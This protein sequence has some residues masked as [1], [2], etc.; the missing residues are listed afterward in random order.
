MGWL[1][2]VRHGQLERK[3]KRRQMGDTWAPTTLPKD[4]CVLL[5]VFACRGVC[6]GEGVKGV[7]REGGHALMCVRALINA[8]LAR[9]PCHSRPTPR[10]QS[11]SGSG[12]TGVDSG[13]E[14]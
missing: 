12:F 2:A 7:G 3:R 8:Y 14:D 9:K 10:F 13:T 1:L 5:A 11:G 6:R 4:A